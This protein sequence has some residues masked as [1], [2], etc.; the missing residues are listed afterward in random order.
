[1]SDLPE[2]FKFVVDDNNCWVWTAY[3]DR[4][5]YARIYDRDAQRIEW[6]HRW[7]YRFHK[8]PIPHRWEIDHTCQ[9]TRCVNP[10]H[11]DAVTRKEHVQRTM[12]RLG[13]D[14]LHAAAAHLRMN[15]ATYKDIAEALGYS[16]QQSAFH[17]VM[18]AIDKGLIDADEVPRPSRLDDEDCEDIKAL[19]AM[20]VPQAVVAEL[21][22]IHNSQVSRVSRGIR[23]GHRR[24]S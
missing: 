21:Y 19:V 22:G 18:K 24:A 23:S 2:S 3:C 20:G 1:M 16:G 4:N 15:G 9:N 5:G 11:L 13:K 10:E 7:S 6:A 8:G 17:A 14:D 12:R